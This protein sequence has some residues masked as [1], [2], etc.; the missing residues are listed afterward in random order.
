VNLPKTLKS[1]KKAVFQM[2][3]E[4]QVPLQIRRSG[5]Q[6]EEGVRYSMTQWFPKM[7]EYDCKGWHANPYVGREFHGVWGDYEVNITIDESYLIGATGV[8]QNPEEIGRGY[9]DTEVNHKKGSKITWKFKAENVIDFAWAADADYVHSTVQVENGPLLHLI[10]QDDEEI[11][12]SWKALEQYS[13]DAM[14]FF[15]E[16]YG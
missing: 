12:E 6:N 4:A 9:S 15:S 14:K 13:V 3:F 11:N 7:C 1:G 16:N 2:E 5:R 10:H 8:L